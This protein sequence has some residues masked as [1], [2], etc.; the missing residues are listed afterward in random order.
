LKLDDILNVG[1]T[2]LLGYLPLDTIRLNNAS[3]QQLKADAEERG[4]ATFLFT[5]MECN[6]GSGA[7][8]VADLTLLQK[9]LSDS[10]QKSVLISNN[11]PTDATEFV[12]AVRTR[13]APRGELYELVA[14]VFND[15]RPEYQYRSAIDEARSR[16]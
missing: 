15:K 14:L 13:L 11:W 6:V 16:S 8:Y 10:R 12:H 9:F 5:E 2:K 7:L 3:E 4:L 1:L